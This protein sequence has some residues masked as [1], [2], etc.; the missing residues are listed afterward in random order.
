MLT[1]VYCDRR[2]AHGGED[3]IVA[4]E[5]AATP[6]TTFFGMRKVRSEWNVFA[7]KIQHYNVVSEKHDLK[8]CISILPRRATREGRFGSEELDGC[9]TF[10][11]AIN[12]SC[13]MSGAFNL[14]SG[15][16]IIPKRWCNLG[17]PRNTADSA[18]LYIYTAKHPLI[19]KVF[20]MLHVE[21]T[22]C[23][24]PWQGKEL[25]LY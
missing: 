22:T 25:Y 23:N 11:T 24:T 10:P 12:N 21:P 18:R 6:R 19:E 20:D 2:L 4:R 7:G 3:F 15:D 5:A 9:H 1:F 8:N 17:I 14:R 13:S 16:R